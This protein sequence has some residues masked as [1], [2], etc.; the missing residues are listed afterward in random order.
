MLISQ[1]RAD[2]KRQAMAAQEWQSVQLEEQQNEQLLNLSE[3]IL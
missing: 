2:E 3:Q 1:D